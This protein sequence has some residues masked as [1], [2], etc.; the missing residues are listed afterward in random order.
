MRF[1]TPAG[2]QLY[3]LYNCLSEMPRVRHGL[4]NRSKRSFGVRSLS[5]SVIFL[6]QGRIGGSTKHFS[7]HAS[8]PSFIRDSVHYF[9]HLSARPSPS[10]PFRVQQPRRNH[11]HIPD[12]IPDAEW[13]GFLMPHHYR[14]YLFHLLHL[15][16]FPST[17]VTS[18]FFYVALCCSPALS[19]VRA[20]QYL[21][22]LIPDT[23]CDHLI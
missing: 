9:S 17:L 23:Q 3:T 18:Y 12:G 1:L 10:L 4:G 16:S 5:F 21:L 8:R 19:R 11:N 13:F 6:V 14:P 20:L 7:H 15:A 22:H 2:H